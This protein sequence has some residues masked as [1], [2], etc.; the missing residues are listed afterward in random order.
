MPCCWSS[1][2]RAR[3]RFRRGDVNVGD[4][5]GVHQEPA[6]RRGA[7]GDE[8]AHALDE[9]AGVAEQQRRIKPIRNEAGDGLPVRLLPEVVEALARH[10]AEDGVGRIGGAVNEGQEREGHTDQDAGHHADRQDAQ[11]GE[12]ANRALRGIEPIDAHHQVELDQR[13]AAINEQRGQRDHRQ[14]RNQ[15]R[16]EQQEQDQRARGDRLASWVLP[17]AESLMV[18]RAWLPV[19]ENPWN[20]PVNTSA[21]PRAASSWLGLTS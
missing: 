17:P 6:H 20:S 7:G 14:P 15:G 12:A 1:L 4:G 8:L 2:F 10:D 3:K 18:V 9:M 16:E 5:L 11:S 19:I 13:K 21:R